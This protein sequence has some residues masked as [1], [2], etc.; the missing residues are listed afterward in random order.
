VL[1]RLAAAAAPD[2]AMLMALFITTSDRMRIS[3]VWRQRLNF[4]RL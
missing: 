3:G 1:K 4:E 2:A